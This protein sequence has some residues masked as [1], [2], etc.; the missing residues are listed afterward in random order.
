MTAKVHIA[1]SRQ[2][3]VAVQVTVLVPSGN[4]VPDRGLQV[5]VVVEA[6]SP[7]TVGVG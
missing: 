1:D 4:G 7:L 6:Q 5:T 2:L 3:L